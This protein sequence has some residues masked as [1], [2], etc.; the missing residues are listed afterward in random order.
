MSF[1][2]WATS[3]RG[4]LLAFTEVDIR[5]LE[6]AAALAEQGRGRT[7]PNPL[8]GAVIVRGE[9]VLGEGFHAGLGQDHAE[10]AAIKDALRRAGRPADGWVGEWG[11]EARAICAGATLYVTLEPC[12][13]YGRTP[14]CTQAILTA[15]FSRVVVGVLDPN[16]AVDGK[17]VGLLRAAGVEVD[18]A[19]GPLVH[20][21]KRQNEGPR[22]VFAVGLPLVTYKYAMSVD[23]R[24]ATDAGESRWISS[25]ESRRLVH[26][27]RAWS[28]AVLIGAGTL[29][30][31]DPELTVREVECFRQPLRVV[32]D[33]GLGLRKESAL[34]RSVTQGPVLVL[35]GPAIPASRLKEVESWGIQTEVV[36]L[37]DTGHID[38]RAVARLLASR[39]VQYVLLEGGPILA[40]AWWKAG[41]IDRVAAFVCPLVLSGRGP[42]GPLWGEGVL[43]ISEA[44]TLADVEESEVGGDVLVTGYCREP[45]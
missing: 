30:R 24:V 19:Q 20:R 18:L 4:F 38:P 44:I 39:G 13:V 5:H 22:K 35:C 15:G 36:A 16:P 7:S 32:V 33:K 26:Q 21:L 12:C 45:Y 31:D 9:S 42:T 17:G 8:V 3:L 25:C 10:V 23:G 6:R 34:V 27:W 37:D 28:D 29:A 40:G 43:R 41:L 2:P 11:E 14:P 1:D